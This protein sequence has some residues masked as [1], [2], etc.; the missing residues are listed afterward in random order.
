[1]GGGVGSGKTDIGSLW[2]LDKVDNSAE[3]VI[4]M[5]TANT[6][7][8][9]ID[10]TTRNVYKNLQTWG[11][12]V[13]PETLPK[14]YTPFNI[15]ILDQKGKWKE[16][17]MR[18]LNSFETLSGVE[19]GWLWCD[20]V[21]QTSKEAMDLV[22]A[23]TRDTRMTNQRLF[24]T[25]LDDPASWM[26]ERFVESFNADFDEVIY[27]TSYDNPFLPGDYVEELKSTYSKQMFQRMC[28][29]EWVYLEG[30]NIYY[31]FGNHNITEHA[32]FDP[33]LPI[34][35]AWDF[36][37][38]QGKPMSSCLCQIK[39]GTH[40]HITKIGRK[41]IEIVRPELHVFDEIIIDTADTGQ[42]V[43]EFK[44]RDWM[45]Q[46]RQVYIYGDSSGKARDTR[47]NRSDYQIIYDEGFEQQR[48]PSSNPP[49]RERHNILNGLCQSGTAQ[50]YGSHSGYST[51]SHKTF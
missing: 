4:G 2:S 33:A 42:A 31:A 23:R 35:W 44:S 6:Y 26:H 16:I 30:L 25:T 3:G 40:Y 24:T 8:Q 11:V 46:Q 37:I 49:V 20:E 15:A 10:S 5:I 47:G 48:V 19:V 41:P 29:A 18:S 22:T 17:L 38:G 39:K 32:E 45:K 14:A 50:W 51:C 7:P 36:N 27:A 21:W 1:M 9:L 34:L 43:Q 28:M 13:R 12:A